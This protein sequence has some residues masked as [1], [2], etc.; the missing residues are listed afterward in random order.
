MPHRTPAVA[1]QFYSA[2][3]QGLRQEVVRHSDPA[4]SP[5]PARILISPHAGLM[6]SGPVAGAVYSRV[7]IPETVI[8]IGPNHTGQGPVLSMYPEGTWGIPGG[9]I[10]IDGRLVQTILSRVPQAEVDETAHT[11]E[12]CLEVQLPFLWN[13]RPDLRIVP[14]V[15]GTADLSMCMDL[16]LALAD[17]INDHTDADHVAGSPLLA[18]TTDMTHYES[19]AETRR[20]DALAIDAIQ[21]GD[22]ESLCCTV[23][24]H[25]ISMC[26]LGPTLVALSA[27]RH[28][29]TSHPLLVRYATS[30]E[31]GGDLDRVVGYAGFTFAGRSSCG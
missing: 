7:V 26:G 6:Y 2:S 1:G 30:G 18:V 24:A 11:R 31:M 14:L 28:L 19:D 10:H 8:L 12:H 21:S 15:L 23:H 25:K 27:A 22:P 29:P 9:E 16:G 3:P 4:A 13:H 5:A 17:I 20:K